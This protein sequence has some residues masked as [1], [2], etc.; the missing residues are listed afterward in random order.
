MKRRKN[1]ARKPHAEEK[2]KVRAIPRPADFAVAY[3]VWLNNRAEIAKLDL[4][5]R[6]TDEQWEK[7]AATQNAA[8]W[9]MIQHPA[10]G[11][12]EIRARAEVL[13]EECRLGKEQGMP[14][15]NRL[16]LM[17]TALVSK[18]N[19]LAVPELAQA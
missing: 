1:K 3:W 13:R 14:T 2:T 9:A 4:T 5:A 19:K 17:A 15:D 18:L 16:L 6:G 11:I 7:L 10:E 8:T 12:R